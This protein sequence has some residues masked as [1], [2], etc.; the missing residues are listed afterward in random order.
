MLEDRA[1]AYQPG[2]TTRDA[3]GMGRPA[4]MTEIANRDRSGRFSLTRNFRGCYAISERTLR[5]IFQRLKESYGEASITMSFIS[6]REIEAENIGTIFQDELVGSTLIASLSITA[7]DAAFS[8]RASFRIGANWM[9][10]V[11]SLTL[12][13]NRQAA[14]ATEQVVEHLLTPDRQPYS[15]L[16]GINYDEP[17]RFFTGLVWFLCLMLSTLVAG[18]AMGSVAMPTGTRVSIHPRLRFDRSNSFTLEKNISRINPEFWCRQQ[19]IG[20]TQ[21]NITFYINRSSIGNH[22]RCDLPLYL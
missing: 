20:K 3:I 14:L 4:S 6:G 5:D 12:S 13:G 21:N 22:Y 9:S 10:A 7:Q 1:L 15:F 18:A 16:R 2:S 11:A 8:N 19:A 17:L